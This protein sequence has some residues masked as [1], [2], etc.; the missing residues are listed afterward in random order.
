VFGDMPSLGGRL[1][2][3]I[4]VLHNAFLIHDIHDDIEDGSEFRHARP[5]G[6]A[7]APGPAWT[8]ASTASPERNRLGLRASEKVRQH[9]VRAGPELLD[10]AEKAFKGAF[11]RP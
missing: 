8:A 3:A 1:E 10:A 9:R 5:T 11:E 7:Q 6:Q 2:A 4:E